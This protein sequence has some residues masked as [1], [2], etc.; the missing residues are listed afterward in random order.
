M[1]AN[2]SQGHDFVAFGVPFLGRAFAFGCYRGLT[3][4]RTSLGRSLFTS[5]AA[6]FLLLTVVV[7]NGVAQDADEE[8]PVVGRW[9]ITSDA[10]GAVWAFQPSGALVVTGPGEIMSEGSWTAASGPEELDATVDVQVTGQQLQALAQVS[11]DG[12][13]IALYVTATEATR[14]DDWRP[15]PA[16]SQL[17]G[18]RFGMVVDETPAPTEA[19]IDCLRPLWVESEVDWDRCDGDAITG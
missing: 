16:E 14:P 5:I 8:H 19:P 4:K 1:A 10:G 2:A 6:V 9:S 17:I 12:T 15:W 7:A 11:A 3:M 18:Q 13:G